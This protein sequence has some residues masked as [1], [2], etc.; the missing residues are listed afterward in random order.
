MRYCVIREEGKKGQM[1]K[2]RV[3]EM[4]SNVSRKYIDPKNILQY[5]HDI[6]NCVYMLRSIKPEVRK[7]CAMNG[8]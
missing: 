2:D 7:L 8:L 4:E 5:I 1:N 6:M 3:S